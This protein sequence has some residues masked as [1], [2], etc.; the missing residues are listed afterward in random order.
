MVS[1]NL[2]KCE[3]MQSVQ[4][5]V[6]VLQTFPPDCFGQIIKCSSLPLPSLLKYS[7]FSSTFTYYISG[8]S[9]VFALSSLS[10]SDCGVHS[11][12]RSM[13]LV[14]SGKMEV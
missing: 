4:N 10:V 9:C 6:F 8:T 1:W 5:F 2:N 11:I 12:C 14:D 13:Y 3:I 7:P